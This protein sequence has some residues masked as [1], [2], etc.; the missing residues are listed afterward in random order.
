MIGFRIVEKY[1]ALVGGVDPHRMDLSSMIMLKDNHIWA[2]GSITGAVKEARS[3]G[4]FSLK[5]EVECGSEAEADE[6]ILAGADVIM[7]DNFD[8]KGIHA[9]AASLKEKYAGKHSFLI[10]GYFLV[11]P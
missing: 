11:K 3:V 5:I 8:K 7:L 9:C 6:A 10:E 4:G 2:H 1:A